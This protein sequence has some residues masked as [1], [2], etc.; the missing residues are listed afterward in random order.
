MRAWHFG[1]IGRVDVGVDVVEQAGEAGLGA[2][3]AVEGNDGEVVEVHAILAAQAVA[4]VEHAL[5]LHGRHSPTHCGGCGQRCGMGGWRW[6][7]GGVGTGGR[8]SYSLG[9]WR[10][11]GETKKGAELGTDVMRM[12]IDAQQKL[13]FTLMDVFIGFRYRIGV[14]IGVAPIRCDHYSLAYSA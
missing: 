11:L 4:F 9:L 6:G 14:G 8:C 13:N 12:W 2:V 10:E 5:R 3:W 7:S 1:A